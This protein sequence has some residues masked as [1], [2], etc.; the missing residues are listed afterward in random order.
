MQSMSMGLQLAL[1]KRSGM[2]YIQ[3][4]IMFSMLFLG[5]GA[6]KAVGIGDL[7]ELTKK[8]EVQLEKK[9][10]KNLIQHVKSG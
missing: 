5:A 2:I 6:S 10:Y 9:G 4:V 7:Q 8:I 3:L 1:P